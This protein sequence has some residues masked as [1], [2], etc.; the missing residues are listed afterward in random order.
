MLSLKRKPG[1]TQ[2]YVKLIM[3]MGR[4]FRHDFDSS[5]SSS[6]PSPLD[7]L[8]VELLESVSTAM[9]FDLHLRCGKKRTRNE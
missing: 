8:L 4:H 9:M 3:G 2:L 1:E 7:S 5:S 6:S